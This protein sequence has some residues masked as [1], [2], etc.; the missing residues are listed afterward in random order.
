MLEHCC[1]LCFAL[2]MLTGTVAVL[3]YGGWLCANLREW[4][5]LDHKA[6]NLAEDDV[7]YLGGLFLYRTEHVGSHDLCR[8]YCTKDPRC[9]A[10]T[11]GKS[12]DV[13]GL[14]DVCFMGQKV[15]GQKP[16]RNRREG[17][18]SGLNCQVQWSDGMLPEAPG[19]DEKAGEVKGDLYCFALMMPESYE[20][21]L[22]SMQFKEHTSV[23]ACDGHAVY[24][25]RSIEVI[26]GHATKVVH[27]DLVAPIGGVYRTAL[28]T[29]VFL[30]LWSQVIRDGLYLDYQWTVKVD[31]D[32]VFLP[33]RLRGMLKDY[34]E[35]AGGVYI[36]NCRYGLHGPIE[37]F[38]RNTV[39]TFGVRRGECKKYFDEECK[40]PCKYGEDW[41]VDQC[42]QKVLKVKRVDN[43]KILTE[44][45]CKP[46]KNWRNCEMKGVASFHPFKTE[47]AYRDCLAK[48]NAVTA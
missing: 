4:R 13:A 24:S 41:Y 42:L 46:P 34:E 33:D 19:P 29:G 28:N 43:F 32:T 17:V 9:G 8:E 36:N 3:A 25:N 7:D 15:Q 45:H 14:T 20:Q 2:V 38:S 44:E 6:C 31:P 12:R 16:T 1:A 35:P 11:W 40:G 10:W 30:Q 47:S 5:L 27:S 26:P 22:L 37:I 48:A 23:F 39:T 21:G 18:V